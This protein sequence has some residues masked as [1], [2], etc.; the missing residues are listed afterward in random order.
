MGYVH[1]ITGLGVRDKSGAA[2]L[3]TTAY[4]TVQVLPE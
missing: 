2:M 3:H 4:Y 1:E